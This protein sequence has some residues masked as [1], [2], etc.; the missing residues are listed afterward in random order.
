MTHEQQLDL[1]LD[2]ALRYHA[3][4]VERTRVHD[5]E[6]GKSGYVAPT[7]P[8]FLINADPTGTLLARWRERE[9]AGRLN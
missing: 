5:E 4:I 3:E 6:F 8:T 1:V 2:L 7:V 9:R